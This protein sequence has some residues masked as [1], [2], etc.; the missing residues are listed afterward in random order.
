[1]ARFREIDPALLRRLEKRICISLPNFDARVNMFEKFLKTYMFQ[2]DID[3]EILGSKTEG[4]SSSDIRNVCRET[5]M[6][7]V[8]KMF[9]KANG[10]TYIY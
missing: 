10:K 6:S 4:Y 9:H 5:C 2:D 8:R 1:M 3:F 7:A